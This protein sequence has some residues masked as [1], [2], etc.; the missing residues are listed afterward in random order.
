[1]MFVRV[2]LDHTAGEV[3][4]VAQQ[5]TPFES[6]G[7]VHCV[8]HD[9]EMVDLGAVDEHPWTD[10]DTGAPCSPS[11]HL[12][13]RLRLARVKPRDVKEGR[14]SPELHVEGLDGLASVAG[15]RRIHDCPC[16]VD[17]I[18]QRLR[19]R[20]PGVLGAKVRAW[21]YLVLDPAEVAAMGLNRGI[22]VSALKALDSMRTARDPQVGS[23]AFVLE[24]LAQGKSD[25]RA[26]QHLHKRKLA[27]KREADRK[28]RKP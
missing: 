16:T 15:V 14:A 18:K 4:A 27:Q 13:H 3:L 17:G 1:M 19:A 2:A 20:G 12:Y 23:R 11:A 28:K 7:L 8:G 10:P 6:G 25:R 9:C 5:D 22:P 26:A 24:R 21:L